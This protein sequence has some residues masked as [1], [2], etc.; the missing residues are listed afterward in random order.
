MELSPSARRACAGLLLGL[1]AAAAALAREP[2]SGLDYRLAP[3]EIAPGVWVIEGA[4]DD[5]SRGNGCNIINT[6]FIVAAEGVLV[7]NTGPSRLYGEQQRQAIARITSQPVRAVL[8]LNLHPDYYFGNQAYHDVP[9][10]ALAGSIRGMRDEGRAYENN[11]F[12]LCG[13]WMKGTE[14]TPAR[15][16]VEPGR[17]DW[18]GRALELRRLTGHTRDDLLLID[19]SSGVIFAGGLVFSERVPT[20]PH[21][22][23]EDWQR[24]LAVLSHIVQTQPRAIVVPSHGPVHQGDIGIRQTQDWL[25]WLD[26]TLR[27]SARRGLDLGEV[28]AAPLPERFRRWAALPAEYVRSVTH[29]YPGHE[30]RELSASTPT[31]TPR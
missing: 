30:L 27:D 22:H 5:F 17:F 23:V 31:L 18:G 9:T 25:G 15:S 7:I 3:R 4:V 6:G 28:L 8:N 11:L 1:A 21:A 20:T 24:S 29:L 10:R 13:D 2:A 12:R 16:T 26:R 14:S 19:H